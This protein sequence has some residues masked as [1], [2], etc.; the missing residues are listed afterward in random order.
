MRLRETSEELATRSTTLTGNSAR[1]DGLRVV[2]EE[3]FSLNESVKDER[4]GEGAIVGR[5]DSSV[6]GEG[7]GCV[8]RTKSS[9]CIE[10]ENRLG[11]AMA[12]LF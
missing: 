2:Y 3:S 12:C 9:T 10:R 4:V 1:T 7:E 11:S 5:M 8:K 6:E